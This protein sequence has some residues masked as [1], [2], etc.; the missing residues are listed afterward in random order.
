M[1]DMMDESFPRLMAIPLGP[2]GSER[3][4]SNKMKGYFSSK[5][6]IICSFDVIL[7]DDMNI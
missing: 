3:L 6:E 7:S 5:L 4:T 2:R 1:I